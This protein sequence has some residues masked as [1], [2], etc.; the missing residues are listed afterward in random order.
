MYNLGGGVRRSLPLP[1]PLPPE[2][3]KITSPDGP[4][5][6]IGGRPPPETRFHMLKFVLVV[7]EQRSSST[8]LASSVAQQLDALP[9]VRAPPVIEPWFAHKRAHTID[10]TQPHV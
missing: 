9:N 5:K 1:P 8:F 4:Y 6:P 7:S 3:K 10:G 2:P